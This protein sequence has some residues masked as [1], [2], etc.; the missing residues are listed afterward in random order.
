VNK[1]FGHEKITIGLFGTCD[2]IPWREPFI[3]RYNE[4]GI[5]Y[6]NPVIDNWSELLEKSRKGL[7]PNPTV[8]ENYYLNNAEVILFPVLKDS[9]GQG[10]LAEMGFSIMRVARN[11]LS[12]NSQFLI[13]LIDDDCTDER[14]TEIERKDSVRSRALVKSKLIENVVYPNII[15]VDT[16]AEMLDYSL[17]VYNMAKYG[18]ELKEN[19]KRA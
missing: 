16:L 19:M 7:C 5:K 6:F 10:S 15:L 13:A 4:L 1:N 14:K 3:K 17:M 12:G 11:I 18:N 9:L 8:T 2:N